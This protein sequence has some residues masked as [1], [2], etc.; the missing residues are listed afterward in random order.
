MSNVLVGIFCTIIAFDQFL[1]M[2]FDVVHIP[3][4]DDVFYFNNI[5]LHIS[6]LS[7]SLVMSYCI[8]HSMYC[9]DFML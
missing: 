4:V 5:L 3:Y 2:Y 9:I 1:S 7:C 8:I 6:L